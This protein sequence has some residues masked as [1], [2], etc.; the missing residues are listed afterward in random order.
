MLDE[1]T[2]RTVVDAANG[3]GSESIN[4]QEPRRPSMERSPESRTT[5]W[6]GQIV[7][8]GGAAARSPQARGN[9]AH[10]ASVLGFHLRDRAGMKSRFHLE[11]YSLL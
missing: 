4:Q 9:D 10:C 6:R 11:R 5:A 2:E 8:A 1:A 7:L 3:G